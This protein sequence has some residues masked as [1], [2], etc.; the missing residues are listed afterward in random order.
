[1]KQI[2]LPILTVIFG[3]LIGLFVTVQW[4][5]KTSR[6]TDPVYSFVTL[7]QTKDELKN[8]QSQLKLKISELQKQIT[9]IQNNLKESQKSSKEQIEYLEKLKKEAGL[10]DVFGTGIVITLDDA[11]TFP[12]SSNSIAHASDMRDLTNVLW[13]VGASAISINNERITIF[14][15]IDSVINTVMINNRK[16]TAP[17]IIA[18]LGEPKT[19]SDAVDKSKELD[20]LKNRVKEEGLKFEVKAVEQINIAAYNGSLNIEFSKKQ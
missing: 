11:K 9:N 1:M 18:V 2:T 14:T 6:A 20:N 17:F 5:S 7:R 13:R 10:T 3:L 16:M 15:S 4:K 12:A 19:L 8:E